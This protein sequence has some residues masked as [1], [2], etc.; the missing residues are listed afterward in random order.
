MCKI[1][2]RIFDEIVEWVLLLF[3][4]PDRCCADADG[5]A[6]EVQVDGKDA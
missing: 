3:A 1:A 2:V 5:Y 6:V 4:G